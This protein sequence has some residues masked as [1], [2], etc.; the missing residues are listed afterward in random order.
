[1]DFEVARSYAAAVAAERRA[2]LADEASQAFGKARQ[3]SVARLAEGDVS[4][5]E[6]RRL[7]LE[8]AR[9]Q[10]LRLEALVARDGAVRV[11]ASL[12]GRTDSA[13]QPSVLLV[14]T[15]LPAPLA[16][17]ADSLV[18][19]ALANQGELRAA[20]LE[21]QAGQ[22]EARRASAA[23]IPIPVLIGGYKSERLTTGETLDGFVAGVS[24]PLPIWDRQSGQV[25]AAEA[26]AA[27]Q[28]AE[29]ATLRRQTVREVRAAF[30]AHQALAGQLTALDAELGAEAASAR[31]SAATAYAEGELSL[32]EWLDSVRAY[33][34]AESTYI[35]LWSEYIARRAALERATG[36]TLF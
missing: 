33:Q 11:L 27:R 9:Y 7:R 19:L 4:G 5:Y 16:P 3:V 12:L 20:E 10:A 21:S 8:A 36:A 28:A 22:A 26:D 15:V 13:G 25:E 29:V 14:D 2:V 34:E 30:D 32:L 17:D 1:V 18:A 24:L 6:H 23:R 35:T 31:R